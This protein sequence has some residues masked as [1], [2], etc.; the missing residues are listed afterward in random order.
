V[1]TTSPHVFD[2]AEGDFHWTGTHSLFAWS[3]VII[4]V[5]PPRV[6]RVTRAARVFQFVCSL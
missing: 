1:F 6:Q 2:A 4:N 5:S 3:M